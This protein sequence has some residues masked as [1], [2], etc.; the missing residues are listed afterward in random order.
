MWKHST[1]DI[2]FNLCVDNFGIKYY[3]KDDVNHLITTVSTKYKV[4][5]DWN[6]S[7]FL[8]FSLDWQ[9]DRGHVTLTMP[10]YLPNSFK[11]LQHPTP[12]AP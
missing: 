10:K 1:R 4:K 7:N 2:L 8:G 12:N 3:N 11:K 9:Y 6:G 5:A